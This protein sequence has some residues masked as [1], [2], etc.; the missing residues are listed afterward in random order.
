LKRGTGVTL[1]ETAALALPAATAVSLYSGEAFSPRVIVLITAIV[2]PVL[3]ATAVYVIKRR[4]TVSRF[5][6]AAVIFFLAVLFAESRTATVPLPLGRRVAVRLKLLSDPRVRGRTL[7]CTARV[8]QVGDIRHQRAARVLFNVGTRGVLLERGAVVKTEGI[9]LPLPFE[10]SEG[11]A[12]YLRSRGV[13]AVFESYSK[14]LFVERRPKPYMLLGISNRLKRYVRT[15]NNRLLLFPQSDFATA[16]LTG[17]R[18]TIP[19]EVM[20]SFKRS[21]TLHILAV[22]GLH[23][24]FISLLIL[25]VLKSFRVP[26]TIV[27]IVIGCVT[28]FY[29][30]FIGDAPSV[31]RASLMVLCGTFVFLFD[32]DRD[33]VNILAIVFIV[34]WAANPLV[35]MN[36]GFLLSFAAT[37][38]I[39]FLVPHL[40][41]WMKKALPSFVASSVAASVGVQV[42]I[43]PVMLSFF[44]SFPYV[45]ILANIPIVPLAG[46]SLA[47]EI[48]YLFLYP[49]FLPLAVIIS[50]SNLFVITLILRTAALFS[51]APPLTV[52]RFPPVLIP[53]Y[54]VG[55]TVLLLFLFKLLKEEEQEAPG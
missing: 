46:L 28:I 3:T 50:E 11:Y 19:K 14:T 20:E 10:R 33:F 31:R 51:K 13:Q 18:E 35:I 41:P 22:S 55:V 5:V 2:F 37:F 47:L 36:P 26:N 17:N 7:Q 53:L 25:F 44:G 48:S 29:M 34:L 9:F 32:R 45:N 16:L 52:E 8:L 43:L 6:L 24:G 39:I 38:G 54:F 30:V 49:V 27:Y 40:V 4:G 12:W 42:Y 1:P 15:V 23:V 21:G